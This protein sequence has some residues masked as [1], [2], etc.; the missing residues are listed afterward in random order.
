MSRYRRTKKFKNNLDYYD[1]LRKKRDLR[2]A[3]HYATP[4]LKN[5]SV[6]ER[7]RII[8]N[9]HIWTLGDRYYK[10][11]NQY[12]GDPSFWWVIAW[13]NSVPIEAD[14]KY[15]DLLEI[16]INIG[17]VLDILGLDY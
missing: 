14:L 13:Y 2:V 8:S 4:I 7:T 16:P 10:L 6:S 1:F 15:G 11:A 9:T 3:N 17:T 12:Y 5:P